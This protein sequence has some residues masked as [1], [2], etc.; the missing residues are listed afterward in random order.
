M[1]ECVTP[2][3]KAIRVLHT[4]LFIGHQFAQ[5]EMH[6][7]WDGEQ[8]AELPGS[9]LLRNCLGSGGNLFSI[10]TDSTGES[11]VGVSHLFQ[12]QGEEGGSQGNQPCVKLELLV[13]RAELL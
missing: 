9:W 1:S 2:V 7:L 4:S 5:A 12:W 13:W 3:R 10:S 11:V 6:I 8:R